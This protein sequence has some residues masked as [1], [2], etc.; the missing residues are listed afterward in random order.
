M[1]IN[2]PAS[3]KHNASGNHMQKAHLVTKKVIKYCSECC[4]CVEKEKKQAAAPVA[5][6]VTVG[7]FGTATR[8]KK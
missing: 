8:S 7:T 5:V 1:L 3:H 4:K 6:K 2:D